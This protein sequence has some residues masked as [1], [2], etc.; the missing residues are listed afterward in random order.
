MDQMGHSELIIL[1]KIT[2]RSRSD[3]QLLINAKQVPLFDQMDD[4][5]LD[6]ICARL[7]PYLCAP[8]T[9]LVREGDPVI[10]MLFI[11]RGRLNSYTTNGGRTGSSTHAALVQTIFVVRNC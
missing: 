1:N 10:E 2:I 9:C 4:R 6:A 5:L 8:G 7:K 3:S 11:V